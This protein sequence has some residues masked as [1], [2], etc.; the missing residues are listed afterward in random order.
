MLI[1]SEHPPACVATRTGVHQY[2]SRQYRRSPTC[3]VSSSTRRFRIATNSQQGRP[4]TRR[5]PVFVPSDRDTSPRADSASALAAGSVKRHQVRFQSV[6]HGNPRLLLASKIALRGLNGDVSEQKPDP[7]QFAAGEVSETEAGAPEVVRGPLVDPGASRYGA[8]VSAI[9]DQ[10]G[11][12][13]VPLPLLDCFEAQGQQL[14]AWKAAADQHRDHRVITQL[15][16]G[17]RF[18]TREAADPAQGSASFRGARRS[19]APPSPD[20]YRPPARDSGGRCRS[21]RTRCAGRRPAVD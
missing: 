6:V 5:A 19:G 3:V 15:A 1:E 18:R 13:P 11:N 20:E 8:H 17:R 14:G 7:I 2:L 10:I 16:R 4:T 9:S 21:P 12:H